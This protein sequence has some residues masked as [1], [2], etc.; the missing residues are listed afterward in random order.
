MSTGTHSPRPLTRRSIDRLPSRRLTA[1]Q[2]I[3]ALLTQMLSQLAADT[4]L[5]KA[6]DGPRL[7]R[8][9]I[10]LESAVLSHALDDVP[11]YW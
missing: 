3:G 9:V 8:V 6:S 4:D 7:E 5:Y 2:G 11:P 10:D 1:Y